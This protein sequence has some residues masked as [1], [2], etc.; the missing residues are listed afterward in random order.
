MH[1]M[2]FYTMT[3]RILDPPIMC[4]CP[5]PPQIDFDS[6]YIGDGFPLCSDLPSKHFLKKNAKY[7]LLGG[8]PKPLWH[9]E[10]TTWYNNP[11]IK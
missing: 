11:E 1:V 5:P 8:D 6:G 4:P 9:W 7:R 10:D 2:Q 3:N